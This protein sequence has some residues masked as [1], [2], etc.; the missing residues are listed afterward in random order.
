[1]VYKG[2]SGYRGYR[3]ASGDSYDRGKKIRWTVSIWLLFAY[4][5]GK[6]VISDGTASL[7]EK[8]DKILYGNVDYEAAIE[9]MGKAVSGE[10]KF[11]DAISE[12]CKYAFL[13]VDEDIEV[14]SQGV[15][16]SQI[17]ETESALTIPDNTTMD[18]IYIDIV[19]A[20]PSD[21]EIIK[22]FGYDEKG[23]F[24]YGCDVKADSV[25]SFADGTVYAVGDS[26]IYGKYV[27]IL[28]DSGVKTLYSGF[29]TVSVSGGEA[30]KMGEIIGTVSDGGL[31]HFELIAN[32][33]YVDPKWYVK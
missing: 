23:V 33:K 28:H 31:L 32:G 29:E 7:I 5:I 2:Q 25:K 15:E 18:M 21:W 11:S 8:S 1:M 16:D 4:C 3:T 6:F 27:I 30:V 24:N 19:Y 26:T 14:I 12:A 9:T 10:K 22:S 13:I 20:L 17:Y